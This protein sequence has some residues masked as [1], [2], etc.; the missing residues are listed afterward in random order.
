MGLTVKSAAIVSIVLVQV[1]TELLFSSQ[2]ALPNWTTPV[3]ASINSLVVNEFVL[4]DAASLPISSQPQPRV[5]QS[6]ECDADEADSECEH[7]TDEEFP[8]DEILRV[9][10][11]QVRSLHRERRVLLQRQ[12]TM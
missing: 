2:S 12:R 1:I 5:A 3:L 11:R 6:R 4:S 10:R 9:L 7:S 8:D